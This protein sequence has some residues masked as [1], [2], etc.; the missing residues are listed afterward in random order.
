LRNTLSAVFEHVLLLPG[1]RIHFICSAVPLSSDI[2]S[3][4][5]AK[6][7]ETAYIRG[8]YYGNVTEQRIRHLTDLLDPSIPKNS[9][10]APYLM[11]IM[12]RQWFTKFA[13]SPWVFNAL[14]IAAVAVYLLRITRE[15]FV[16][17]STGC[18]TMGSEILVIFA[19][20][21]YF[22]YIYFQIGVIVTVFLA[23]LLPGAMFGHRLRKTPRALLLASDAAL[24]LLPA[25]FILA[26]TQAGERLPVSFYLAFGFGVSVVCGFQFPIALALQKDD[27]RAATRFFSADL[28][29]AACGTLLTSVLLI[30]YV[31]IL[32]TAAAFIGLK[33]VS[34]WTVGGLGAKGHAQTFFVV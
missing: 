19:F 20:Q 12:F 31:G 27:N 29:G 23:G 16:L 4:L 25:L 1:R 21:I 34:L 17:F 13:A 22:G 28:I 18:T 11:R 8:Y 32:W 5:A 3:L 24:M 10:T 14:L 15:E 7:I 26:L 2:P 33:F 9:D 6:G 30:P